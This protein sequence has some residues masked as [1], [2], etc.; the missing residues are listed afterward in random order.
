MADQPI[1]Q[2]DLVTPPTDAGLRCP[3]CDY[4]LTGL[5]EPRCPECGEAFDWEQVRRAAA[6]PPRI[7]FERVRGWRKVPGFFV[8]W[9][10]VLFAPWIFAR[11]IVQRSSA[12]HAAVFLVV[13]FASTLLAFFFGCGWPTFAAWLTTAAIYIVLQA[14]GL[15][16]LDVSGWREPLATL[17][18]WLLA[19]CY[20][21]AV[22]TTEFAPGPPFFDGGA[23]HYVLSLSVAGWLRELQNA[24]PYAVGAL[25]MI[26]WVAALGSCYYAR[27][28][29]RRWPVSLVLPAAVAIA[30]G[31]LAAYAMAFEHIG[32]H[33][34]DWF[35]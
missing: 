20:T 13:C 1:P 19:G 24:R 33:L 6:N 17:R 31:T 25:Q 21:S 26:L 35:D 18:F 12:A 8:T 10:T 3:Q 2:P 11:Q 30:L 16:L 34:Y 23:L 29:C 15:S 4:N 27:L 14:I 7:Y 9:A 22:M 5:S 32:R 28:R